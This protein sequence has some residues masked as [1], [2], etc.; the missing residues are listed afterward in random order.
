MKPGA[1][2]MGH[3]MQVHIE[4]AHSGMVLVCPMREQCTKP[5]KKGVFKTR[6][7]LSTH[8]AYVSRLSRLLHL[9]PTKHC[10]HNFRPI[11]A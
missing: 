7:E 2:C 10:N 9:P 4:M 1:K 6:G 8:I 3:D 5:T 11:T